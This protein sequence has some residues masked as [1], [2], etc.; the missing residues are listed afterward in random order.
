MTCGFK[1]AAGT[2]LDDIFQVT[3]KNVGP[4]GFQQSDGKDLGNRYDDDIIL[5]Y[6]VGYR[7]S[8]GTD[9]GFLRGK[10][11]PQP[12]FSSSGL[13]QLSCYTRAFVHKE[14]AGGESDSYDWVSH[15]DETAV[16]GELG[17][18]LANY[19]PARK[20][21]LFF[22]QLFYTT[23]GDSKGGL[24]LS[25]F[26]SND[27]ESAVISRWA[28]D[29]RGNELGRYFGSDNKHDATHESGNRHNQNNWDGLYCC[30]RREVEFV[31]SRPY[32]F[33][34]YWSKRW[35]LPETVWEG[36]WR[37]RDDSNG[38]ITDWVYSGPCIMWDYFVQHETVEETKYAGEV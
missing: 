3:D 14:D 28:D 30:D 21:T 5:G 25:F 38:K 27:W 15:K 34:V 17:L 22:Q 7:N 11:N 26:P 13:K 9:I 37:I 2:D 12:I 10:E 23:T 19:N 32:V 24:C 33:R 20:Y 1:D 36:R 35:S 31:N 6:S 8:A 18:E 16:V 4:L 29:V